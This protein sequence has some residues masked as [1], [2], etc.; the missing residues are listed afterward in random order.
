MAILLARYAQFK[1]EL[2]AVHPRIIGLQRLRVERR[3]RQVG[4]YMYL[5][6]PRVN[7]MRTTF[8]LQTLLL[9]L[10]ALVLSAVNGLK[11]PQ[12]TRVDIEYQEELR[13]ASLHPE[14]SK[15]DISMTAANDVTNVLE[16]AGCIICIQILPICECKDQAD[17]QYVK[18]SCHKC[19]HYAC[20]S[21]RHSKAVAKISDSNCILC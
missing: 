8:P 14:I 4:L 17:C 9:I 7:T 12:R 2:V 18:Q 13:T 19:A 5:E 21:N 11:V 15:D 6:G 20:T 3:K 10:G 1:A 16:S